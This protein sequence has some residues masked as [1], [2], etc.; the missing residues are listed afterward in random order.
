MP[1]TR[2]QMPEE[3]NGLSDGEVVAQVLE[4]RTAVFEILMRRY[5]ERV[6]RAARAI[7]RDERE[8]EDVARAA[9]QHANQPFPSARRARYCC[10]RTIDSRIQKITVLARG[11][12]NRGCAAPGD[13]RPP[14]RP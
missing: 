14:R 7:V 13:L 8:A 3:W 11:S 1:V 2:S 5:N 10:R 4:G 12:R 9:L 6:Y